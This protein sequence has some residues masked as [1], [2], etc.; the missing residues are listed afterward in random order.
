[1][2][3]D[4]PQQTPIPLV[5]EHDTW[6]SVDP[7][8]GCPADCAYCYLGPLGLRARRPILRLTPPELV[9]TVQRYLHRRQED[10]Q[11]AARPSIPMCIG[12]YTDMFMTP[13]G[14]QYL[15]E[16][17]PLHAEAFTGHP[18]CVVTKARLQQADVVALDH[19]G[20]PVFI[21]FSQSFAREVKGQKLERGP[22]C[23]P[24][25]TADNMQ[26][27]AA[28]RN[29]TAIH[30]WR[31]ITPRTVPSLEAAIG[32][33]TL[34]KNA[35]AIASIAIGLKMGPGVQIPHETLAY[36][37]GSPGPFVPGEILPLDLMERVFKAA[38]I[39]E[40]PVYRNT[41]CALA[42]G[43]AKAETL[44][45][46]RTSVR[47]ERC[48]PCHCPQAQRSRC[49][50]ARSREPWPSQQLLTSI[51]AALSLSHARVRWDAQQQCIYIDADLRQQQH[52]QLTHVT[53]YRIAARRI[54]LELSW[55]GALMLSPP[56]SSSSCQ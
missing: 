20:Y 32:Q 51:A 49:E 22:T 14:V 6:I 56:L 2:V 15:R 34:I 53:G 21:F 25:E 48:E 12:N 33:L 50:A 42:L 36:F 27:V 11:L 17:L 45:A 40:H 41:S 39:V 10:W 8:L 30:F 43:R 35:G 7:W 4:A 37:L 13:E 1:M 47:A 38:R 54:L 26:L 46:W 5:A 3:C 18:L 44:G 55:P 52:A 31:P 23:H 19:V 9:T 16:Y 28:S 24:Q 29:L